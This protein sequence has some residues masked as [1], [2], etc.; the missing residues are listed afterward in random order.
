MKLRVVDET[1]VRVREAY[2]VRLP[3]WTE[4][5]FFAETP[6][7]GLYEFKD[8]EL[9]VHS[10]VN[11]EHQ[12]V[13]GFLSFLL[14][15]VA[16]KRSLGEVFNGPGVFRPREGLLREPDVFF[17]SKERL[18][19]IRDQYAGAADF[20]I[21]VVSEG[22]HARDLEEKAGEYEAAGVA[23]YWVVDPAAREVVVHRLVEGSPEERSAAASSGPQKV[24][25]YRVETLM[26]GRLE[27]T[28]VPGFQIEVE[29]LWQRPMP[30]LLDCLSEML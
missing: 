27:S 7:H 12:R 16:A 19:G 10:P 2:E 1:G 28:A 4:D 20:V 18:S 6:D 24:P 23:E 15:G 26:E 5:R 25:T 22:G 8:G 29:W 9:I 11:L 13:V 14:R 17:I 30:G 21:E 3:G